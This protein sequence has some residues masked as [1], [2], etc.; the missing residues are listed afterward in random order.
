MP[1]ILLCLHACTSQPKVIVQPK[2]IASLQYPSDFNSWYQHLQTQSATAQLQQC[3]KILAPQD[4]PLVEKPLQQLACGLALLP[5]DLL[6][7]DRTQVLNWY[8]AGLESV[9]RTQLQQ[10]KWRRKHAAFAL[11]LQ[12]PTDESSLPFTRYTM[13][14]DLAFREPWLT[15][16]PAK[17]DAIG[18]V[19]AAERAYSKKPSDQH[20]PRE[21]IFRAV[22]VLVTQMQFNPQ[23]QLQLQ[24]QGYYLTDPKAVLFGQQPYPLQYDSATAYLLLLREARIDQAEWKALF[25]G[26]N[27]N[28]DFGIYSI[29]PFSADK[30]P[31]LMIHGLHSSPMIWLKLSH[32]IYADPELSKRYQV[33]H[34][35]YPSGAPP[36]FNAMRLRKQVDELRLHLQQQLDMAADLPMVLI[37]HS[38]GG[39]VAKTFVVDPEYRLWDQTF[40]RR[41]EQLPQQQQDDFLHYQDVFIFKPR[42]YVQS[43]FFLDTPH[44]GAEMAESWYS[45]L[46][47]AWIRLPSIFSEL[48]RRV[49]KRLSYDLVTPQM[50]PYLQNDGPTSVDV[51]SPQ[52][53]LLRE[54]AKLP[55]QK[56]VYSIVGSTSTP[57]CYNEKSCAQLNDSVVPFFSAHQSQAEEEIIVLSEHNSYQSADAIHF[58]L[59]KLRQ[60]IPPATP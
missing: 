13:V 44:H 22:T 28:Y 55:Y 33:W 48:N 8:Q 2:S 51:L 25:D 27:A 42:P 14:S 1:F 24:L 38:M 41:P 31:V 16:A 19:L 3:Q 18:I 12:L 56:P 43:V 21:G 6:P 53:P 46:A 35:F 50:K 54:L 4:S 36:F 52:H 11:N 49:F 58:I 20:Y 32:A 23:G 47:S 15:P 59:E 17:P 60:Q 7:T 39:I 40:L 9:V 29:A 34:A 5:Q 26:N 10:G 57:F 30:I 45:R 37:G